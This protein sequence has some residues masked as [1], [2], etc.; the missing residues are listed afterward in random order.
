LERPGKRDAGF[1]LTE[2]LVAI[3]V[4][5]ILMA[6]GLPAFLRAYRT[7]QLSN[8]ATQVADILRLARYEAIRLNHP[9]QCIIGASDASG[10]AYV[11]VDSI[12]NN[13]RDPTEK[14]I[15]LGPSGHLIDGGGV[16]GAAGMLSTAVG[17]FA[18]T[19]P[20]P[21]LSGISF[22][23]RGAVVVS[24]TVVTPLNKVAVFYLSSTVAPDAG[25]RAVFLM[26]AG[27][28]QIWAADSA[29]HWQQQR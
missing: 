18:T 17:S 2:L 29:G 6:V 27:S 9:V 14:T 28:I 25:Y 24:V 19:P 23:A 3:A 8:A 5:M 11:W 12:P 15:L 26:P 21:I 4:A 13:S 16:P 22:D 7:Y 10:N 20:S 1:S